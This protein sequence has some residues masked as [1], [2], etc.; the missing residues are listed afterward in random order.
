MRSDTIFSRFTIRHLPFAVF[1]F[2]L[3]LS[4]LTFPVA[5]AE[6]NGLSISNVSLEDRDADADTVAVEFDISWNNSWRNAINHDAAWVFIK[7]CEDDCATAGWEHADLSRTGTDPQGTSTGTAQDPQIEIH[8]PTDK[9]GAFI[10][11]NAMHNGT[12]SAQNVRLTVDYG[13]FGAADTDKIQLKVFGIEMVFIPDGDFTIGDGDGT[14]ESSY[15]FH[16]GTGNTAVQITSALTSDIRVDANSGDDSQIEDTGIGVDGDGGLDT[17][18]DGDIN[19][20]A[21][22]ALFPTGWKSFYLM[23]YEMSQGQYKDF[24]NTLTQEQQGS[25]VATT[26]SGEGASG[27]YVMYDEVTPTTRDTIKAGPDPADGDPYTFGNDL[28]NND[29]FNEYDDGEGIAM[30][31]CSWMDLLAYADWSGLRPMTELEFEKAARGPLDPVYGEYAWGSTNLTQAEGP[32]QDAGQVTEVPSTSGSGLAN[33]SGSGTDIS[34]PLRVGFAATSATSRAT[35]GAGYY[36]N[37]ELNGNI[38]DEVV[39]VG[40]STGRSFEGSHG[41]GILT[42]TSSYEGNATNTD[43]PGIDGTTARGVTG[44]TGAG[45]RGG[46]Y[47][48]SAA[49]L[50]ISN[51]TYA[52][53]Q[54][55][56]AQYGGRLARTEN[57]AEFQCGDDL[58]V[59]HHSANGVAP[60]DR[61]IRYKTVSTNLTGSSKCWITQ[62]LG[63]TKQAASATDSTEAAAGW[64]WQF[65]RKQ[66]YSHDGT[67]RTPSTAWTYPI[68]EDSDWTS[69]NDPCTLELGDG[70]RLPTETEWTNADSNGSWDDYNDTYASV[71]K[72]HAAGSLHSGVG[73]LTER[74]SVGR[75]WSSTQNDST[76]GYYLYTLF[77]DCLVNYNDKAYGLSGRCLK[78]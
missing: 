69:A 7:A 14:N 64:Y 78:D 66:G 17:N 74:G 23:K 40:N 33:Y 57:W 6:A 68:D 48:T 65:N 72:L 56:T 41:D 18:D 20:D 26:L 77:I 54:Y 13:S 51:R 37:M 43:W 4:L 29:V 8:V 71:L 60:Y 12:I 61:T 5:R 9:K 75:Y 28:N 67:T 45:L 62:N 2:L 24:L 76:Y 38:Y 44:A 34:A 16:T 47:D 19:D 63:A 11:P 70:W 1:G 73:E 25:R 53:P 55:R 58:V 59:H 52:D 46:T 27:Y 42:T 30:N 32:I 39:T 15:A 10:R 22:N 36:G 49:N 31:Y 35:A 3:C 50:A 21:D